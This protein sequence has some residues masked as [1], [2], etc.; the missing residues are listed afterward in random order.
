MRILLGVLAALLTIPIASASTQAAAPA[1]GCIVAVGVAPVLYQRCQGGCAVAVII[2]DNG[3]CQG[4]DGDAGEAGEDGCTVG[5][6][7]RGNGNCRGGDGGANPGRHGGAG[8]TGCGVAVVL[9]GNRNCRGGDGGD[10]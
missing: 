7:I 5:V 4:A 10:A 3:R 8:G 1:A 6:V 2:T 9:V